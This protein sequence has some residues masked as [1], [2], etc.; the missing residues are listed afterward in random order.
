MRTESFHT[1]PLEIT[2]CPPRTSVRVTHGA[3]DDFFPFAGKSVASVRNG[4]AS[5]FSIPTEAL[6]M[7]HGQVVGPT[8]ILAAG[9]ELLFAEEKG[10]KGV[11]E[12]VWTGEEFC[13]FLKL[14][15]EDLDAWIGQGLKVKRVLDGSLRITETGTDEF[16]RGRVIKSPYMTAEQAAN[17]LR[18][19]VKG[20]Y[21]LLERRKLR[22]LPGSRS[23]LFTREMLDAHVRGEDE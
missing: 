22:K 11:G 3:H 13:N 10:H 15:R 6:P 23:I 19:T 2:D 18:T 17:Y 5:S 4:L 21:S 14:T 9:E 12:Q 16:F 7:L 20:I 8:H 1:D